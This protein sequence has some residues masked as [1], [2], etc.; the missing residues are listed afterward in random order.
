MPTPEHGNAQRLA[1]LTGL[2]GIAAYSVLI[3][4]A[5]DLS[6][7]YN[8]VFIFRAPLAA[9]GMSLFFVLSGF[10]IQYSY[11][12]LFAKHSL[13]EATFRFYVARFA[14]LYP[15]YILSLLPG[16]GYIPSPNFEGHWPVFLSYLTLTQSWFNVEWAMFP[17]DWSIST[18]W[19]FYL[20][21]I[22][23]TMLLALV[24]R[25]WRA[26]TIVAVCAIVG[27]G[28]L[29]YFYLAEVTAWTERWFWHG[30]VS[31]SAVGWA[32]YLAPYVRL[33][34][35]IMGMLAAKAYVSWG[36]A[37]PTPLK[38]N[39]VIGLCLAWIAAVMFVPALSSAP[40]I[41]GLTSNFIFAPALA[42]LMIYCC[43][44]TTW[45][46]RLLSSPPL[47]LAGTISYSLYIWSW[48]IMNLLNNQFVSGV[49]SPLAYFNSSVKVVLCLFLTTLFAYGSYSLYEEPSR[50]WLRR[51]LRPV[52][53]YREVAVSMDH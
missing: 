40:F 49:P 33:P 10:V 35:F 5:R 21:F 45:L 7:N 17:P 43:V 46:S 22:P 11:A 2:R 26:L 25:P 3:A 32:T 36:S 24:R 48:S 23:L 52:G 47:I 9:F 37:A 53:R 38:A 12:S 13:G 28:T 31:Y 34:E 29:F 16:L 41:S 42:L 39:L 15:L 18:E 44:S 51:L 20:V 50:R 6:F 14:R 30:Q 8:G 19:F 27:L 4:H 1:P